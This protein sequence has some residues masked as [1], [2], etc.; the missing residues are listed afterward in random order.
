MF[1][2]FLVWMKLINR[3]F[4][5]FWLSV[6]TAKSFAFHEEQS[7]PWRERIRKCRELDTLGSG[8]EEIGLPKAI[9]WLKNAGISKNFENSNDPPRLALLNTAM[10]SDSRS[11]R[12]F[13]NPA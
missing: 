12:R 7:F 9:S 5:R 4:K 11:F 8:Q 3:M 10:V 2:V 1:H 13:K 6:K